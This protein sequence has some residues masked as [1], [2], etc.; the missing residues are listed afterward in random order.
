M[1]TLERPKKSHPYRIYLYQP[2]QIPMDALTARHLE[3]QATKKRRS[4][5]EKKQ[6]QLTYRGVPYCKPCKIE[7]AYY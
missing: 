7:I 6:F 4:D 1:F 5:L 3:R 2:L